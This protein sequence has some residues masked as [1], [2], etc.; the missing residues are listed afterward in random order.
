MMMVGA[1]GWSFVVRYWP[2][3][4][5]GVLA[6]GGEATAVLTT[7]CAVGVTVGVGEAVAS[8]CPCVDATAA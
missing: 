5:M 2:V 6:A 4:A 7:A 3:N 1:F 8:A